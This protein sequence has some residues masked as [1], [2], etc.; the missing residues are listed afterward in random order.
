MGGGGALAGD[1]VVLR[2]CLGH[3]AGGEGDR[4]PGGHAL[5]GVGEGGQSVTRKCEHHMSPHPPFHSPK[6]LRR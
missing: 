3:Y 4:L 1:A 5:A 6:A 2:R